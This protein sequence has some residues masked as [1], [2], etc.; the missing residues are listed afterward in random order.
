MSEREPILRRRVD[1]VFPL[2]IGLVVGLLS[3]FAV[4][5]GR[6]AALEAKSEAQADAIRDLKREQEETNGYLRGLT[7]R[8][9][10]A[11]IPPSSRP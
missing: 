10:V 2:L 6:I 3:S 1:Q 5:S 9:G 8:F 4:F 7:E 11:S